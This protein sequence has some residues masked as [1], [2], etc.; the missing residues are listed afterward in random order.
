MNPEPQSAAGA[1]SHDLAVVYLARFA[2]G[3]KPVA[4]FVKSY[5]RHDA[6]IPHDRVVIRKGFSGQG[7]AQD[8]IIAPWSRHA[9]DVTDDGFDITAY[10][11]VAAQLPHK[12]VVF[13]NTFS[14]IVADSWLRKLHAAMQDPAVGIAGATG[15]FES[16]RS[17]MKRVN[18]G[19][20]LFENKLSPA[21]TGSRRLIRFVR[22]LLP[23]R[24]GIRVASRVIT[25]FVASSKKRNF[26]P[27]LEDKFE[28]FWQQE[29][30]PG[31]TLEYLSSVPAFPNVHMRTNAFMIDRQIF[32][33]TQPAAIRDKK[34]SYLF[35]S[36]QNGLTQQIFQRGLKVVIVGAD[37]QR[38]DTDRWAESGTF[39][40]GDQRNLLVKD[41]QTRAFDNMDASEKRA[42]AELTW[43]EASRPA[44]AD[45]DCMI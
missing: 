27:A 32:L 42:F 20:W 44:Q 9:Y 36:G 34:D 45:S 37:G 38:Y 43:G 15:S 25:Y 13:L 8:R 14:E 35:E 10:A 19:W 30:R 6:G 5:A 39:R 41:N 7:T 18:K 21:P 3:P 33:D 26:N 22:K 1:F 17:S 11:Q 29:I 24:F 23:R 40:L 2:E 12:H 28:T 31:G 16:L 4:G